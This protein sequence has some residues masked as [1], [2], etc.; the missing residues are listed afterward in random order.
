MNRYPAHPNPG[1]EL[2]WLATDQAGHVAL[3][4]TGGNGPVPKVVADHLADVQMAI[5][6][7]SSLPI[8]GACAERPSGNGNFDS[9]FEPCRR[10]LFGF[11]WGPV[12]VGPCARIAVPSRF[13]MIHDVSDAAVRST[14]IL[15]QLSVDFSKVAALDQSQL[16]VE[17]YGG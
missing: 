4:S 15:V 9:W 14:A 2:D 11:D 12:P 3:F 10:G 7:V 16:G 13:V 6:Q 5:K 17:L 1:F 8:L